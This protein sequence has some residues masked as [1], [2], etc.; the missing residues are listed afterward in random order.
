[1]TEKIKVMADYASTGL[2]DVDSYKMI[3]VDSL[4]LSEPLK[5]ELS[6]WIA[7][8][9]KN[10]E[11]WKPSEDRKLDFDYAEFTQKGKELALKLKSEL[12]AVKVCYFQEDLCA[13]W[14]EGTTQS[15][16]RPNFLTYV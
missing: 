13:K 5:K 14:S 8:Y 7:F 6:D 2:W 12:P 11:D 4:G 9:E 10:C 3:E 15:T 1:M 16:E